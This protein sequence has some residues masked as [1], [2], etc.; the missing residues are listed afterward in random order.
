MRQL[1]GLSTVLSNLN[2]ALT[3]QRLNTKEGLTEAALIVKRDSM[4]GTPIDLGNLR[5]SAFIMVTDNEAD[6]QNPKF[7]QESFVNV[8]VSKWG[9]ENQ[10]EKKRIKKTV[11]GEVN[12][13]KTDHEAALIE[14]RN[15]VNS[16]KF[17]FNAIVGYTANYALWVHEMPAH[18]NFNSGSNKF[19][20]KA[21]LKNRERI[22][23]ILIK[24]ATIK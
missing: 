22:K 11:G 12:K 7:R 20:Q 1:E 15:I 4:K 13:L 9:K 24:W 2:K 5:N 3:E 14:G 19:L 8:R 21:L 16:G 10:S 18:Y 23:K 17:R 6:N